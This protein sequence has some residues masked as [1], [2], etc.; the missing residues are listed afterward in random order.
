MHRGRAQL[1]AKGRD[2]PV[3]V[4]AVTG[5]PDP[6]DLPAPP[7]NARIERF[8]PF[9]ALMPHVAAVITNVDY[10]GRSCRRSDAGGGHRSRMKPI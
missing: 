8:V 9:A 7:P 4:I 5:G 3:Q 6:A 10:G 2:D 1:V